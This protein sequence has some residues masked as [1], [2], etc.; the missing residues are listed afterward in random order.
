M[1]WTNLAADSHYK[2]AERIRA[3]LDSG[4]LNEARQGIEELL[5]AMGRSDRR[6]LKSQLIR[7]M[8]HVI[9]WKSQPERRSQSWAITILHARREI[10]AIREDTP[11][12]GERAVQEM[13]SQCLALALEEAE[14]E[15]GRHSLLGELSR[16][17]VFSERYVL[18]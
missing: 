3:E 4:N 11:S 18:S 7:L 8:A 6:A 12:L 16:E 15:M 14:A 9:K 1:E 10:E 5:E 17:E 13:W 2:T